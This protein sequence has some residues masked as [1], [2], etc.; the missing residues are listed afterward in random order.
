MRNM[1]TRDIIDHNAKCF[2]NQFSKF[3]DFSD[4]KA[5]IENIPG[6]EWVSVGIAAS[7]GSAYPGFVRIVFRNIQAIQI[8]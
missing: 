2:L 6:V 8:F 3:I 1:M 5:I 7:P 4:G